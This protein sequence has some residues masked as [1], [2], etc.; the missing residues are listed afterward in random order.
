MAETTKR[1]T[2]DRKLLDI[3]VCP[4]TKSVLHY[5]HDNQE[6]VSYAAKVA[7]PIRDSIPIMLIEE[8][9]ELD[10]AELAKIKGK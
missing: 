4:V 5:D 8:A 2:I 7:Y 1:L 9:R 6:L 3:L 10:E